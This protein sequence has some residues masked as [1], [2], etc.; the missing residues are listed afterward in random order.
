MTLYRDNGDEIIKQQLSKGELQMYATA[1]IWG[2]AKTS[3][4][5]L[6]F[7]IDTPL[8]RLDE[9]HRKNMIKNFYPTAAHQSIIFST[10]TEIINSHYYELKPHISKIHLIQYDA[11]QDGSIVNN[12]YFERE[13]IEIQ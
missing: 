11:D 9:E 12:G 4:R 10:N 8:A 2:L 7:I 13:Q 3:A 5:S 6:P 1:I